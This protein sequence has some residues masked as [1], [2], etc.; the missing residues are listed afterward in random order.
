MHHSP[1]P[2]S[3]PPTHHHQAIVLKRWWE[4]EIEGLTQGQRGLQSPDLWAVCSEAVCR[5]EAPEDSGS[6]RS[7]AHPQWPVKATE[8]EAFGVAKEPGDSIQSW[9]L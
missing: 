2:A 6:S 7:A 9:Y 4:D 5:R 3:P 8:E 1:R